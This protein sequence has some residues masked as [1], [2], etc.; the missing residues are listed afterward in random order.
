VSDR[1]DKFGER[2]GKAGSS[3]Y[4]RAE[5]VEAPADVLDEGVSGNDDP[6]GTVCLQ[7][8]HRTESSFQASVVGLDGVVGMGLGVMEGRWEQL[9]E[10]ARIDSRYRSVVTSAGE[11]RVRS[12]ARAKKLRAASL[13]RRDERYKSMTWPN[14]SM[15]RNR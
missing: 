11:I 9:L 5:I 10:D 7:P 12:I 15:A 14:W 1:Q 3:R 4:V 13:F 2:I 8:S 6:G